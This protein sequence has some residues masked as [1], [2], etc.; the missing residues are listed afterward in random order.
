[1]ARGDC[2]GDGEIGSGTVFAGRL[3]VHTGE[4]GRRSWPDEVKRRIVWESFRPGARVCEVARRYGVSPQQ[5]T[6]WGRAARDG[7]LALP[8]DPGEVLGLGFVP[9]EVG[10]SA[11][12]PPGATVDMAGAIEIMVGGVTVRLPGATGAQRIAEVVAAL[13]TALG[14]ALGA[15]L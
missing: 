13:G 7:L 6:T 3:E 2:T 8:E 12:T 11:D 1:M 15:R 4:T 9:V 10:A 14:T 5:V